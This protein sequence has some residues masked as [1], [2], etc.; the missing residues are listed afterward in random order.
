[1]VEPQHSYM[2]LHTF[3]RNNGTNADA[4]FIISGFNNLPSDMNLTLESLQFPNILF[5]FTELRRNYIIYFQVD[6]NENT[7]IQ[8]LLPRDRIFVNGGD[9]ATAVS[10]AMT[11]AVNNAYTFEASYDPNTLKL[12]VSQPEHDF[13]FVD[14]PFTGHRELG[15]DLEKQT[16]EFQHTGET[17]V[18]ISGTKYVDVLMTGTG[19][20]NYTSG[21]SYD[22]FVR[23]PIDVAVGSMVFYEPRLKHSVKSGANQ[24]LKL[25]LRDDRGLP[26]DLGFNSYVSY[27]FLITQTQ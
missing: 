9:L 22:V 12:T 19:V 1:M 3:D 25:R 27:T 16:F 4:E 8:A 13:K 2:Y 26:V 11:T 6:Q 14:G 24:F 23:V 20:N 18:D 10:A 17:N 7:T 21:G 15:Y 5:P